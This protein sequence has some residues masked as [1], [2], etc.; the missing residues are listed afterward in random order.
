MLH[1]FPRC[2]NAAF[3]GEERQSHRATR[4]PDQT[5]RFRGPGSCRGVTHEF[6]VFV[7]V[8]PYMRMSWEFKTCINFIKNIHLFIFIYLLFIYCLFIY[9]YMFFIYIYIYIHI[10]IYY[11]CRTMIWCAGL[12]GMVINHGLWMGRPIF[13]KTG[14]CFIQLR[15]Q[16]TFILYTL[17]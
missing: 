6:V 5:E 9:V 11:R 10:Y 12:R 15:S 1:G 13:S 14:P 17:W 3:G 7:L 16:V 2:L 8:K 4:C